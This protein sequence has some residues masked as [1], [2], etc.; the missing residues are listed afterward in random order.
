M[1]STTSAGTSTARSPSLSASVQLIYY[2][3]T[4]S[5]GI[6]I[7]D[8]VSE[9]NFLAAL[10]GNQTHQNLHQMRVPRSV[11]ELALLA[12]YTE[13]RIKETSAVD[14]FRTWD[15]VREARCRQERNHQD[16]LGEG[17]TKDATAAAAAAVA[18]NDN[19]DNDNDNDNEHGPLAF[20]L[21]P[22]YFRH[23]GCPPADVEAALRRAA[24]V[25]EA[26]PDFARVAWRLNNDIVAQ[27][28]SSDDGRACLASP[29]TCAVTTLINAYSHILWKYCALVR[30]L[31]PEARRWLQ[32]GCAAAGDFVAAATDDI[33]IAMLG[34]SATS[35][36]IERS[37]LG[38]GSG[39]TKDDVNVN[40]ADDPILTIL[41][42][43]AIVE[44]RH[45]NSN[46]VVLLFR[47]ASSGGEAFDDSLSW[48]S[49]T[50]NSQ[51]H[52]SISFGASVFA[53]ALF[54]STASVWH[55]YRNHAGPRRKLRVLRVDVSDPRQSGMLYLPTMLHPLTQLAAMG[56]LFHPRTK[57]C[58]SSTEEMASTNMVAGL[59]HTSVA[60]LPRC[61][62]ADQAQYVSAVGMQ[63][64]WDAIAS[65]WALVMDAANVPVVEP[66]P[67]F[68]RPI[69]AG[70]V[71]LRRNWEWGERVAECHR[72]GFTLP[73]ASPKD[74][75][76]GWLHRH[77]H[78]YERLA[79]CLPSGGTVP[80]LL[81]RDTSTQVM[82]CLR[83]ASGDGGDTG[84]VMSILAAVAL[85]PMCRLQLLHDRSD[86]CRAARTGSGSTMLR[87]GS[88][89]VNGYPDG[90]QLK[91]LLSHVK[92]ASLDVLALQE[93]PLQV[94]Q[95]LAKEAGLPYLHA[96]PAD[97]LNNAILSRLPLSDCAS[98]NLPPSPEAPRECSPSYE[99][100]SAAVCTVHVDVAH[101]NHSRTSSDVHG[102]DK[103]QRT[104]VVPVTIV[105]THLCHLR[106]ENRVWQMNYLLSHSR[107]KR[108]LSAVVLLGDFNA[109]TRSDFGEASWAENATARMA[110]GL[111]EPKTDLSRCLQER[112]CLDSATGL[113]L[114]SPSSA[115][116]LDIE[117]TS[118]VDTRVDYILTCPQTS[119]R[120]VSR[121]P[122][123]PVIVPVPASYS[124]VETGGTDHKMICVSIHVLFSDV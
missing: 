18:D 10:K 7:I 92:G 49:S 76:V 75:G 116:C 60:E 24:Y 112:G 63:S 1:A 13:C 25:W 47:V 83:D 119:P 3:E 122:P 87:V 38:G 58:L 70:S 80:R 12:R 109:V 34:G 32:A 57:C 16:S 98:I 115:H 123:H 66:P 29:D 19:D 85:P 121:V 110:F 71:C 43:V 17:G 95:D 21:P 65:G 15:D 8:V 20:I 103:T 64:A 26:D 22:F 40:V 97:Y 54:D 90:T 42:A 4:T 51:Q 91:A 79:R 100:R 124:A 11:Y 14:T 105:A 104:A 27:F 33:V 53:G 99:M 117:G 56:E 118:R 84:L 30:T 37:F 96:S 62:R 94:A 48:T 93:C 82:S 52:R 55:L 108:A 44:S 102:I 31:V 89:N 120:D 81:S 86:R 74:T 5:E 78:L 9:Q 50:G 61:L 46:G 111:E 67:I 28:L 2:T 6:S 77:W 59:H 23:Q 73:S 36:E 114:G 68:N 101:D 41:R 106:E 113:V 107:L 88:L 39:A 45:G 69:F 35:G 72:A